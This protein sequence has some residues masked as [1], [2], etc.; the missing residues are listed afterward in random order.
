MNDDEYTEITRKTAIYPSDVALMYLALGITSEVGEITSLLKKS[1]RD[2][3]PYDRE[4]L[5]S[6]LG[7]ALWYLTRLAD[8]LNTSLGEL[9]S[10]N[11]EKLLGRLERG[12]IGGSGEHR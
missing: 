6:E 2:D 12:T 7:D 5:I 1:I 3:K 11:A 8:T 4:H 9:K 10:R